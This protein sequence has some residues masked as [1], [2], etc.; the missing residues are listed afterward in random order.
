MPNFTEEESA[1]VKGSYDYLGLN[2]YGSYYARQTY[3]VGRDYSNDHRVE[4]SSY[5]GTGHLIGPFAQSTWLNVYPIG[6]RK[7]LNWISDRYNNTKIYVFENGVS[8]PGETQLP[9][10]Q[11][12]HD[13]F[14]VD[15]YKGYINALLEA[16]Y[17]DQ[18][19]IGGYFA[20]SLMDNFEWA[21]GYNV[22]FGMVYVDYNNNQTRHIKDSAYWY[23]L[24]IQEQAAA[25]Q[26]RLHEFDSLIQ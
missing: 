17:I 16:V 14:R 21:D 2:H 20:W 6:F 11:A 8:V 25:K 9:I 1:L 12:V 23:S 15:F 5:N 4:Y 10:D 24:F 22:R 13:Q 3:Q 26:T 18:V 19:N 7:L